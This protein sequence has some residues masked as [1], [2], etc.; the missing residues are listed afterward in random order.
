MHRI[1]KKYTWGFS[2]KHEKKR[3]CLEKQHADRQKIFK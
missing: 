3:A 1:V 2:E